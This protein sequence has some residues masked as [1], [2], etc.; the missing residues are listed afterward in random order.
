MNKIRVLIIGMSSESGGIESFLMNVYRH[1]NREKICCDFLTFYSH[2]AFENELLAAG[3]KV[4]HVTRRGDNPIK[5]KIELNAFFKSHADDYDFVWF[6]ASSS[7]NIVPI[8]IAK[9]YTNAKTIV[10]CHGTNFESRAFFRPIHAVMSKLNFNRMRQNTD[11]CF[12]C[13][14]AAGEYLFKNKCGEVRIIRNGISADDYRFDKSIRECIRTELN[15]GDNTVIIGHMGR[16]CEIKNQ[17][18]LIRVFSSYLK[19]NKN[20]VLIISGEGELREQLFN[21][22]IEL[23]IEKSV[24]FTGYRKDPEKLLQAFDLFVLPSFN[25]GFPVSV[26][27]AQASGLKCLISDS[28]TKEISITELVTFMSISDGAEKWAEKIDE[29]I[30]QN[31]KFAERPNYADRIKENGFDIIDTT[32][33]IEEFFIK[34]KGEFKV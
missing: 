29:I 16:L 30:S 24:I 20:S 21:L 8:V 32:K 5:N 31:T 19:K 9:K 11:F 27:E 13:S 17:Q 7:S 18:F 4:Y 1:M 14:Y 25:E 23:G 6:Q 26:I 22:A 2:C 33:E 34:N 15:I 28:V 12:A 10:H 3:S